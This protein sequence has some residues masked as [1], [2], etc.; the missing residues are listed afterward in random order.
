MKN[1]MKF[2]YSFAEES[3]RQLKAKRPGTITNGL[4]RVDIMLSD[5]GNMVVNEFESL[6]AVY[7]TTPS[8]DICVVNC[9]KSFWHCSLDSIIP[10]INL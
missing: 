10:F 9:L 8:N 4:V 5:N 1:N 7:N 2:C 6:E 3:L